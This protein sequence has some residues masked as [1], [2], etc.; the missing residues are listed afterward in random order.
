MK[1]EKKSKGRLLVKAAAEGLFEAVERILKD[2]C[3]HEV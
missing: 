2:G 1:G 3:N